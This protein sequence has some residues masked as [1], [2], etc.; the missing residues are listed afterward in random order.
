[1]DLNIYFCASYHFLQNIRKN[2][3]L[4]E[5]INNDIKQAMLAKKKQE[6]IALRGIKSMILLAETEKGAASEL[7]A[8]AEMKLLMKA[9]KQRKES[10]ELYTKEGRQDLAD[11]ENLEYEVIAR[12]LPKAL[13]EEELREKIAEIIAAVG[14]SAPSDMGKVMGVA[15]KQLAGLADG[16]MIATIVKESLT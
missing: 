6:L 2:M 7:S 13:S 8:E 3:G 15:T 4:K 9:A 10:S 12:Y 16:K 11:K 5:I 1:M 14:A